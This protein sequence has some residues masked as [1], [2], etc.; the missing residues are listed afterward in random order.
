MKFPV[1]LSLQL[2]SPTI[3]FATGDDP[4]DAPRIRFHGNIPWPDTLTLGTGERPEALKLSLTIRERTPTLAEW[5]NK[6][7][8]ELREYMH[9]AA[10]AVGVMTYY[11]AWTD[12]LAV[13]STPSGVAW[14]ILASSDRFSLLLDAVFRDRAPESAHIQVAGMTWGHDPD[15]RDKRWLDNETRDNLSVLACSFM[16]GIPEVH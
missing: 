10:L 13:N 8:D 1:S 15:G 11:P 9:D 2:S 7:A 12:S 6:N 14:E 5:V 16:I 3:I 4:A